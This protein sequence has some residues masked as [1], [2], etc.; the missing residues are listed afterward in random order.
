MKMMVSNGYAGRGSSS[1]GYDGRNSIRNKIHK[2]LEPCLVIPPPR[3][4]LLGAIIKFLDGA[5]IGA[6]PEVTCRFFSLP[7]LRYHLYFDVATLFELLAK[8]GFLIISVPYKLSFDHAIAARQVFE[9][10]HG[11]LDAILASGLLHEDV[12]HAQ[13]VNL[14]LP[15]IIA[16]ARFRKY[17]QGAISPRRYLRTML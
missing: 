14:S 8:E 16:M 17:S 10:F 3:G 7:F 13:L 15:W 4:K 9:R 11:R 2:R 1:C 5:I 12:S 6:I